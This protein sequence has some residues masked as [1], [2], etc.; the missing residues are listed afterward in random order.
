MKKLSY[1]TYLEESITKS[2][3]AYLRPSEELPWKYHSPQHIGLRSWLQLHR[4]S[5]LQPVQQRT[6]G[7]LIHN[8]HL[9]RPGRRGECKTG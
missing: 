9:E 6:T 8:Q 3:E 7:F 1:I 5:S 2:P 4:L